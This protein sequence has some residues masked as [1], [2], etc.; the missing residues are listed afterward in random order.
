MPG[1]TQTE[2]RIELKAILGR[3]G[4]RAAVAFLNSLTPHRFTSFFRFDGP[5][6]QG[7]T[8][9]DRQNPGIENC[10]DIPIETSYCVFVRDRCASFTVSDASQDERVKDHPKRASVQRYCGV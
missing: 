10:E 9:Y 3:D 2:K 4:I 7:V 8:F 1:K 6:L 5:M